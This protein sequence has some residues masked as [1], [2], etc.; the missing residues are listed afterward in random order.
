MREVFKSIWYV[1]VALTIL[2]MVIG[3]VLLVGAI[4]A[5]GG[6]FFAAV[7]AIVIVA[8]LVKEGIDHMLKKQ[9]AD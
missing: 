8:V 7:F 1:L 5:F 9:P 4:V 2:C 6:V 3:G